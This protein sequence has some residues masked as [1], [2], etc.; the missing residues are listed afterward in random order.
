MN[1]LVVTTPTDDPVVQS[2]LETMESAIDSFNGARKNAFESCIVIGNAAGI[3]RDKLPHGQFGNWVEE[4][5]GAQSAHPMTVQWIRVCINAAQA[6]AITD[7]SKRDALKLQFTDVRSLAQQLPAIKAGRDPLEP[8]EEEE[9][10]PKEEAQ[11]TPGKSTI[12]VEA[13][14][15]FPELRLKEKELDKREKALD[16]REAKLD[17][18]EAKLAAREATLNER[19]AKLK[20]KEKKAA[21][22]AK[23]EEPIPDVEPDG[24]VEVPEELIAAQQHDQ[25]NVEAF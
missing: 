12:S 5:F 8:V 23:A 10:E 15:A 7:E 16:A 3:V 2:C 18:R 11:S 20:E 19:E 13:L 1:D 22:K 21:K 9:E 24:D 4:H 14:T 25:G 6:L 17:K